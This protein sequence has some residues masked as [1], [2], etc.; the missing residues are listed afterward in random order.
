[1]Y[2]YNYEVLFCYYFVCYAVQ[3]L[4][5]GIYREKQKI[6]QVSGDKCKNYLTRN[7]I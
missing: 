1:M 6:K 2:V 4:F 7:L 3:H 5:V